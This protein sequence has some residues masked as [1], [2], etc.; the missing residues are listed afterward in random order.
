MA[1][2]TLSRHRVD[3]VLGPLLIDLRTSDRS[4]VRPAV[5]IVH[6][7]KGFKDWGM[8]PPLAERVAR[9]GFHTVSFNLSGSGVDDAGEFT[10]PERFGHNT[11]SAELEDLRLVL[12]ALADGRLGTPATSDVGL[13]GHSRGGGIA[14]IAASRDPRVRA[15]V[16]WAAISRVNRWTSEVPRWRRDGRL[17]VVNS[18][19]GQVLP[20]YADVLDDITRNAAAL[21][22]SDAAS[23]VT[24]PWLLLHGTGDTSV[25]VEEAQV[26]AQAAADH[27]P[28]VMLLEGAGHT[29]GAVH[30]YTGVTPDLAIVFDETLK[31]MGR[32]L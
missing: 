23:R 9:A 5:V 10:F 28:R 19:T 20:L 29:F 11:F 21:D 2:P 18:R 16:T 22:I 3:G 31:W 26:L 8:F 25:P 7:F 32:H 30:P 17:D 1:T 6:G 14:V 4:E 15:L 27:P 12:D 13:I 24:A